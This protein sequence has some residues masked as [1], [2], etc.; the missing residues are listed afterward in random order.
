MTETE[1]TTRNTMIARVAAALT[2]A[3]ITNTI[4]GADG[5][6]TNIDALGCDI[7]F[8]QAGGIGIFEWAGDADSDRLVA[9]IEAAGII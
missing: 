4:E 3:N 2:A 5:W 6:I 9:V 1:T 8:D 7:D